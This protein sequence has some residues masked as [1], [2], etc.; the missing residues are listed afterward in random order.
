MKRSLDPHFE[1]RGRYVGG[2]DDPQWGVVNR[3]TYPIL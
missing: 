2:K 3:E 1:D